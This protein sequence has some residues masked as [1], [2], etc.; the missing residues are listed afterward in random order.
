MMYVVTARRVRT[1]GGVGKYVE[2]VPHTGEVIVEMGYGHLV[3]FPGTECY[4]ENF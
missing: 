2:Y 4:V 1:P 3:T